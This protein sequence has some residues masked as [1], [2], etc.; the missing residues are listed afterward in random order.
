MTPAIEY[1][2]EKQAI[3]ILGVVYFCHTVTNGR[4]LG[5]VE[6]T[7]L[8]ASRRIWD[9]VIQPEVLRLDPR[10]SFELGEEFLENRYST[11]KV[12]TTAKEE[13]NGR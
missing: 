1:L 3:G 7:I 2:Y 9:E 13:G 12:F 8:G 4:P 5:F 10:A 11:V 6:V